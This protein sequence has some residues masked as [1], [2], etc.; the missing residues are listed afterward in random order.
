MYFG[1]HKLNKSDVR[2]TYSIRSFIKYSYVHL[3]HDILCCSARDICYNWITLTFLLYIFMLI[4]TELKFQIESSNQSF[5]F[6]INP[7]LSQ[8]NNF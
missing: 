8:K 2:F 3:V 5:K 7:S 6:F 4:L 1:I